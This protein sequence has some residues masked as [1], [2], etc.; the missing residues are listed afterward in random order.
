[1]A[2]TLYPLK[3]DGPPQ[4]LREYIEYLRE[5][6]F[7][8]REGHT[9]DPELVDPQGNPVYTWQEGYPYDELMGRDEY[10][11]E[12]YRLQV[13]LLKF[14]YWLEDHGERVI[15]LFE[16]RDAAG[17]GGTIKRFTEHLNPR[18]SRVV[19]LSKP[20]ER[21]SG[22]WYFQRYVRHLPTSG[23]IVM[24]DRSWYN[25]AGVERVMGF[26]TDEQYETFMRQAPVF[27]RMLVESGIH[28][29]KFWF[30]VSRM[31]QRT[32]FA[33]RQLD[34]VRRWKLSPMDLASLG[35]WEDYTVAKE[36]MFRRTDKKY[37]PWTIVRSNDKKRARLNAM[38]FFL[39]QFEY[40]G[41]DRDV[42]GRPDPLLVMR[43][44][45]EAA[46]E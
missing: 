9:A 37:A 30:S 35:R 26:C 25:R 18:T 4:D 16:G 21:E 20:S 8:V 31:E 39:G 1:M 12:K 6:G 28:V 23:E 45:E 29:T 33:I 11:L 38:R 13:E 10:E 34:P 17:K 14:Q 40:D 2:S 43:G 27:E 36:E 42:V 7:T 22:E 19:A 5:R 41:K 24:F 15:I 44:K 32:R 3:S 46:D